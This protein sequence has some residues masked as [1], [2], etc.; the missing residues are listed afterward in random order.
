MYQHEGCLPLHF[1]DPYLVPRFNQFQGYNLIVDY[2]GIAVLVPDLT[3]LQNFSMFVLRVHHWIGKH[4]G[5]VK[6]VL[7]ESW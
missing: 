2:E 3:T 7:P 1:R 6:V 5:V 4:T